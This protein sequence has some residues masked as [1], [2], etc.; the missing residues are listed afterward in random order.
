MKYILVVLCSLCFIKLNAQMPKQE[1]VTIKSANL[2]CWECKV[3]LEKYLIVENKSNMES[4]MIQWKINLLQSEIKVQYWPDRTNVAMI[5]AALNNAGFD[6]DT[7][8]AEPASYAKLLP[9]CK[10]VEEGGGP[11]PKKPCHIQPYN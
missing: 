7:D 6:A 2:K 5:K 11:Q 4:G 10:R 9:I 8:K 3:M 1:W